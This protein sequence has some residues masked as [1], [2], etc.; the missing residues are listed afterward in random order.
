MGEI[1]IPCPRVVCIFLYGDSESEFHQTIFYCIC[2]RGNIQCT[3][4]NMRIEL[5][6]TPQLGN[7]KQMVFMDLVK[8]GEK[9]ATCILISSV[10]IYNTTRVPK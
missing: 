3:H 7:L 10:G 6:K 4:M 1:L 9:I 8:K 2:S 5:L